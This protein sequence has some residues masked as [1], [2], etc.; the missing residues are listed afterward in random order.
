MGDIALTVEN[1][2][3]IFRETAT[4]IRAKEGTSA[5]IAP[6]DFAQRILNLPTGG[7][8][9]EEF[10]K[11]S[12]VLLDQVADTISLPEFLYSKETWY[13]YDNNENTI[14]EQDPTKRININTIGI[15]NCFLRFHQ[16]VSSLNFELYL[17]DN[18]ILVDAFVDSTKITTNINTNTNVAKIIISL[19]SSFDLSNAISISFDVIKVIDGEEYTDLLIANSDEANLFPTGILSSATIN[20]DNLSKDPDT[21]FV[22]DKILGIDDPKEYNRTFDPLAACTYDNLGEASWSYQEKAETYSIY[23]KANDEDEIYLGE[24]ENGDD[25]E[26]TF[27]YNILN[28]EHFNLSSYTT[29]DNLQLNIQCN[30]QRFFDGNNYV[31]VNGPVSDLSLSLNYTSDGNFITYTPITSAADT[32]FNLYNSAGEKIE[33]NIHFDTT[34]IPVITLGDCA[35]IDSVVVENNKIINE[36]ETSGNWLNLNAYTFEVSAEDCQNTFTLDSSGWYSCRSFNGDTGFAYAKVTFTAKKATKIKLSLQNY[37]GNY[38]Y[39]FGIISNLNQTLEKSTTADS[40]TQLSFNGYGYSYSTESE[41]GLQY[42]LWIDLPVGESFITIKYRATSS[43]NSTNKL[44][45]K[46]TEERDRWYIASD[47]MLSRDFKQVYYGPVSF[48]YNNKIYT[49][50]DSNWGGS[51]VYIYDLLTNEKTTKSYPG[52]NYSY[53]AGIFD[54]Q[55]GLFYSFDYAST[56]LTI[57]SIET[58][59][60]VK[61]WP[62]SQVHGVNY[63]SWHYCLDACV[64]GS[65]I[66]FINPGSGS[67][68]LHIFDTQ[69]GVATYVTSSQYIGYKRLVAIN[70]KIYIIGQQWRGTWNDYRNSVIMYDP[71]TNKFSSIGDLPFADFNYSAGCCTINDRYIILMGGNNSSVHRNTIY[72]YD[73]KLKESHVCTTNL[74]ATYDYNGTNYQVYYR[75]GM[76]L[77][78]QGNVIYSI[79]GYTSC[80]YGSSDYSTIYRTVLCNGNDLT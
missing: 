54:E 67:N 35:K 50:S 25:P 28:N 45:F 9:S 8:D 56:C 58:L 52:G 7:G 51:T 16:T 36:S 71:I 21:N 69:T 70:N 37:T 78:A 73:T 22:L 60:I 23:F 38:S 72:I 32:Y 75:Y 57:R 66:Y 68:Y 13:F 48:L 59:A 77:V 4:A 17:S 15:K 18:T 74:T 79:G 65:K 24:I 44:K 20:Y 41:E 61:S 29:N 26:E 19:D 39:N 6:I 49:L 2:V 62:G 76:D 1:L 33:T 12:L 27:T 46:I 34:M 11:H 47:T 80:A 40:S 14:V 55:Q 63:S 43:Y 3:R 53:C 31:P 64:I 30:A 10:V 42:A 5:A